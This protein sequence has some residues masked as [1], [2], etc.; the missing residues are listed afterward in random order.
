MKICVIGAGAQGSVIAK[1][2]A[3]DPEIDK[4]VL[5]DINTQLLQRV[6][7]KIDSSKLSTERVD[8]G[9]LDD[10]A[11]VLKGADVAV[12]VTLTQYNLPIFYSA[13]KNGAN[14]MDFAISESPRAIR[15]C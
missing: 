8:A 2:L 4:V 5:A 1:I 13:L 10:L 11:K 14:Y 9:N 6:A 12:N 15:V 7:K 3:E